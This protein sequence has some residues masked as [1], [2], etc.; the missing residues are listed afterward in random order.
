MKYTRCGKLKEYRSK[1]DLSI[2]ALVAMAHEL[3]C[4]TLSH[5][6][7]HA[8]E[9]GRYRPAPYFVTAIFKILDVSYED[10]LDMITEW[11]APDIMAIKQWAEALF[12]D[13]GICSIPNTLA[14][15]T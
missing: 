4:K 7:Y 10:R 9:M 6:H 12:Q 1:K 15:S 5:G 3:G 11:M 13:E 2:R 14:A 8:I